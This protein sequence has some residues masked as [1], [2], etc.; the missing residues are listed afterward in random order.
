VGSYKEQKSRMADNNMGHSNVIGP[1]Q[2]AS[3]LRVQLL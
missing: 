3:V 1:N 2:S